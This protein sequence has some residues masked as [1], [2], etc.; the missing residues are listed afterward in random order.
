MNL[1]KHTF[2]NTLASL[3]NE[4][5][6]LGAYSVI[7]STDPKQCITVPISTNP[8]SPGR[9]T[10]YLTVPHSALAVN[11]YASQTANATLSG[12]VPTN[13]GNIAEQ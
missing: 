6:E 10:E 12:G 1:D 7:N 3:K 13:E 5:K 2:H 11:Q 4:A 8:P 9:K